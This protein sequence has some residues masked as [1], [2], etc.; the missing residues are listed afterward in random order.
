MKNVNSMTWQWQ[1]FLVSNSFVP[2]ITERGSPTCVWY[3]KNIDEANP[4]ILNTFSKLNSFQLLQNKSLYKSSQTSCSIDTNSFGLNN[5]LN[6]W[7]NRFLDIWH[8]NN[9]G[10][11]HFK[12]IHLT[13]STAFHI[14]PWLLN[15][16]K[17]E[18]KFYLDTRKS[19]N[20]D[21]I[22]S[23]LLLLMN[24]YEYN[25]CFILYQFA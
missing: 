15:S 5:L 3:S 21:L 7:S 16:I 2:N 24:L 13:F 22:C 4:K 17:L 18:L 6:F 23:F 19:Q 25:V 8:F 9:I 11:Y 10:K 1:F 12:K 20:E 14:F